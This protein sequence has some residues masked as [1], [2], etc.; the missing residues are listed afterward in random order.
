[1]FI[2]WRERVGWHVEKSNG[3]KGFDGANEHVV[4]KLCG[5]GYEEK[6]RRKGVGKR[7]MH[8]KGGEDAGENGERLVNALTTSYERER[9]PNR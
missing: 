2:S 6:T 7:T 5:K 9:T 8:K 3:K 4:T 1:M